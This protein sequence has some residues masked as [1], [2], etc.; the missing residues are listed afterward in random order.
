MHSPQ[1]S[2]SKSTTYGSHHTYDLTKFQSESL[3]VPQKV[4]GIQKWGLE[5]FHTLYFIG[6]LFIDLKDKITFW[7]F[8]AS[9]QDI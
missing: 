6:L 8:T 9:D 5:N 3:K 2:V 1:V 4:N 7:R